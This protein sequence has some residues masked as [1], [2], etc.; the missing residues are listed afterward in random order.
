MHLRSLHPIDPL[1]QARNRLQNHSQRAW[2]IN[3][4]IREF[5]DTQPGRTLVTLSS[6]LEN[7]VI[8]DQ[9]SEYLIAHKA[10]YHPPFPSGNRPSVRL[11]LFVLNMRFLCFSGGS[12]IEI[13]D[14]PE[15]Y[16]TME[17]EEFCE[18]WKDKTDYHFQ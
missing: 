12:V 3:N 9:D 16:E 8:D 6:L 15:N 11:E 18:K 14:T 2:Q 4:K 7:R 1:S 17:V 10:R 5:E 13:S